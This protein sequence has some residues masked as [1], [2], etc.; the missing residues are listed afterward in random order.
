[1][2]SNTAALAA[3]LNR[4]AAYN[5][6]THGF[7]LSVEEAK[8]LHLH[9]ADIPDV[10]REAG[11]QEDER[12]RQRIAHVAGIKAITEKVMPVGSTFT[13]TSPEKVDFV[14]TPWMRPVRDGAVCTVKGYRMRSSNGYK[15]REM[16]FTFTDADGKQRDSAIHDPRAKDVKILAVA[17]KA[18]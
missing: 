4:L 13:V 8:A 9:L 1:M 2:T 14:N 5:S 7:S 18:A 17:A 10:L 16:S 12:E 11:R 6:A 15:T 3:V